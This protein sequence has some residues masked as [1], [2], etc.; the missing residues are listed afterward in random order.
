[1][2]NEEIY[3]YLLEH[4][5]QKLQKF[6]ST[7]IPGSDPVLGVRIPVLRALAKRVA[8][9]DFRAYLASAADGTYEEVSLQGFVIGYAKMGIKERLSYTASFLPK[10][11]DWAVNDCFCA[12]LG[13]AK[14]HRE[15]VWEF[16]MPYCGSEREFDQRFVAVM[17]MD[18]FLVDDYIDRVFAVWD[19]LRHEGYYC[20]MGVAWGVATAYAKYPEKT[21]A[22]LLDNHLDDETYNKAIQKML[23]SYRVTQEAKA[24]LRGMKR[25]NRGGRLK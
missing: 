5:E 18:H 2:T 12:T 21:H 24:V 25:G 19:S 20:R 3:S 17:L 4:A 23:E 16:L 8:K 9:E 6:N 1:M 11:H 15:T 10:I 13:A 7:L 22:F 14:K